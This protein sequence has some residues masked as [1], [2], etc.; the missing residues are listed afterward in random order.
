MQGVDLS[1][2]LCTWEQDAF[3]PISG[4]VLTIIRVVAGKDRCFIVFVPDAKESTRSEHREPLPVHIHFSGR[5]QSGGDCLLHAGLREAAFK[6]QFAVVCAEPTFVALQSQWEEWDVLQSIA[7]NDSAPQQCVLSE[8]TEIRYFASIL[9]FLQKQNHLFAVGVQDNRDYLKQEAGSLVQPMNLQYGPRGWIGTKVSIS[10]FSQGSAVALYLAIC[11]PEAIAS[12]TQVGTGVKIK[13]DGAILPLQE[14]S[15]EF[16]EYWP[17]K[18]FTK[19]QLGTSMRHCAFQFMRDPL[20]P[21]QVT[22]N[23]CIE[24]GRGT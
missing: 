16:C 22:R 10:G 23:I 2:S 14:G 1:R 3:D 5:H 4:T 6:H 19:A 17:V 9:R 8:S 24:M 13:G 11:F 15:C 21:F 7:V 12:I 18:I 20:V